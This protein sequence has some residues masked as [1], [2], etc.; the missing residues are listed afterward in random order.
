MTPLS[1]HALGDDRLLVSAW[2]G[3][4]WVL[5]A[6][7]SQLDDAAVQAALD[8]LR[9]SVE[10]PPAL[11]A[12]RV[13][14]PEGEECHESSGPDDEGAD[15]EGRLLAGRERVTVV[16]GLDALGAVAEEVHQR[17][18]VVIL[19]A[20]RLFRTTLTPGDAAHDAAELSRILRATI[21]EP[22]HATALARPALRDEIAPLLCARTSLTGTAGSHDA[23][24][25]WN[26]A[27][28]CAHA[29][30]PR[31]LVD[32][33]TGLLAR[34]V[35]RPVDPEAPPGFVH[36]HA[37]L[38]HLTSVDRRFQPDP[39]APAGGF[40][41][42]TGPGDEAV[43]SGLAHLCGAY[44]GQGRIRLADAAS[45]RAAGDEVL[46][47]DQWRPHPP[48]L[49]DQPGFP[50]TR[51]GDHDPTWWLRGAAS[52][53]TCWVP[54]S[55]VHAGYL[56]SELDPLPRTNGHNL[57]GLAA[58]FTAEEA[59]DRAAAHVI[60]HDAV[61][62]WWDRGDELADV[63]APETV[64]DAWDGCAWALRI[65]AV[66]SPLGVPVRLAVVDDPERDVVA[67]G[68][69]C[70]REP[71]E[72]AEA[73]AASALVQHA[74]ARDLLA[75][76]SLIREAAALGN[77]GV[78][79]LA[80]FDPGRRYADA[81]ADARHLIDPMCHLQRGLDPRVIADTRRRTTPAVP[82]TP[83]S[84]TAGT[85]TPRQRSPWEALDGSTRTVVVDVATPDVRE[86][87]ARAVRVLAPDLRR[88]D[89][90]AFDDPRRARHPY[91]GW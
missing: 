31:P 19:F 38:P 23:L 39:L 71:A 1:V 55:L 41:T 74:S 34:I 18:T 51:L 63:F 70:A 21:V 68:F 8:R 57:V 81:F 84:D 56:A 53:V 11:P 60:A 83:T 12:S 32:P 36:L 80:P 88:L 20:G 22:A 26:G 64:D 24:E 65:L 61:A 67:L 58:G 59:R 27:S 33:V 86:A 75:P 2:G 28:W 73:A 30:R 35:T 10:N 44:L 14:S 45:L 5:E 13:T 4:R 89:V 85:S 91:P 46:T 15:G 29:R 25:E 40:R 78:A 6:P 52:D 90:A 9:A 77:G 47:V 62:R 43:R 79:G 87:G 42:G 50:F 3:R 72:A 69:A 54:L 82:R 66:P 49:H 7:P 37:E 76:A 48:E 16:D 17:T